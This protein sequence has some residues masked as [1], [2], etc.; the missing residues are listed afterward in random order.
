MSNYSVHFAYLQLLA[1]IQ[2][3]I[4]LLVIEMFAV[5]ADDEYA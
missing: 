2:L 4:L 1:V 3:H 5:L